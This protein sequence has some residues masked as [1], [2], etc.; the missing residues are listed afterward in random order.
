MRK[1]LQKLCWHNCK[2]IKK[3]SVIKAIT[4]NIPGITLISAETIFLIWGT[5]VISLNSLKTLK[6]LS[7]SNP[8]LVGTKDIATKKSNRLKIFEKRYSMNINSQK[9]SQ[10]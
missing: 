9:Q 3:N 2:N 6:T 1:F 8:E 7:I 5:A 10:L 4:D